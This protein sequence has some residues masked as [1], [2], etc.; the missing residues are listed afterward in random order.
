MLRNDFDPE[1][2]LSKIPHGEQVIVLDSMKDLP[3]DWETMELHDVVPPPMSPSQRLND[4]PVSSDDGGWGGF[5]SDGGQTSDGGHT[6][7]GG[8]SDDEDVLDVVDGVDG[9]DAVAVD[10]DLESNPLND[11]MSDP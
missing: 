4:D 3:D 2:I 5:S 8:H 10:S 7:D 11:G 1:I 9:V 6:T